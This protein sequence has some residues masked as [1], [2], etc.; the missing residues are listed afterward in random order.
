VVF[1]DLT[2]VPTVG[3]SVL[4]QDVTFQDCVVE[5]GTC[6]IADGVGMDRVRFHNLACGDALRISSNAGLNE[7]TISA[8]SRS[9]VGG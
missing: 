9:T 2:V 7:V 8:R 6:V 1:E 4:I 3:T 5:P